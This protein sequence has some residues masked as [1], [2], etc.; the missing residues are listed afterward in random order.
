M[1]SRTYHPAH[2]EA[3]GKRVHSVYSLRPDRGPGRERLF[4]IFDDRSVLELV[5][6]VDFLGH[7]GGRAT[8]AALHSHF[9]TAEEAARMLDDPPLPAVP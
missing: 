4:I 5:A 7:H 9:Y 3:A 6:G 2:R 1:D 8:R